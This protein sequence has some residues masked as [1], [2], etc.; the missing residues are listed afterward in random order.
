MSERPSSIPDATVMRTRE[1][2]TLKDDDDELSDWWVFS[3]LSFSCCQSY[4]PIRL[5]H[6]RLIVSAQLCQQCRS[7]LYCV[8]LSLSVSHRSRWIVIELFRSIL[9]LSVHSEILSQSSSIGSS[10]AGDS[11][12][13]R[14]ETRTIR[15]EQSEDVASTVS[16]TLCDL[17]Q[18]EIRSATVTKYRALDDPHYSSPVSTPDIID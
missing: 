2:L 4:T 18:E 16:S 5:S 7:S 14:P 6:E 12:L 15:R 17:D 13:S 8:C 1:I 3:L 9:F 10:S 11:N